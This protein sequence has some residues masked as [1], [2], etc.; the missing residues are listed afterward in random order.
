LIKQWLNLGPFDTPDVFAFQFAFSRRTLCTHSSNVIKRHDARAI[1]RCKP[2]EQTMSNDTWS[3]TMVDI[4][5][6]VYWH[7]YNIS[8]NLLYI[9]TMHPYNS[10]T[11]SVTSHN[12]NRCYH[13]RQNNLLL[14]LLLL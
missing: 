8:H 10:F 12:I 3:T 7:L 11:P 5:L 1:D 4:T 9:L 13:Y 2:T 14:L 6:N